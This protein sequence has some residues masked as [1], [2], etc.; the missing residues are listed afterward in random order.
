MATMSLVVDLKDSIYF[1]YLGQATAKYPVRGINY[2]S[3]F[4]ISL[5]VDAIVASKKI[6]VT[7]RNYR[8]DSH[9]KPK[10]LRKDL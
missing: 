7:P 9:T 5:H 8:D 3:G 4:D 1:S 2:Y 10:G 6:K